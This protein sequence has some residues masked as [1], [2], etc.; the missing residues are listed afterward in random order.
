M[1]RSK[2]GTTVATVVCCSI[3]S[4]T[5]V[6]YG[7]GARRHGRSRFVRSYQRSKRGAR[8]IVVRRPQCS[9]TETWPRRLRLPT[10]SPPS[11]AARLRRS[12]ACRASATWST[13]RRPPSAPRSWP[14]PARRRRST[15]TSSSSRRR[16]S[17]PPRHRAHAADAGQAP[18]G[19]RQGDRRGEGRRPRAARRLRRRSQ[20][21]DLPS[22]DRRQGRRPLQGLPG[23]EEARLPARLRAAARPGARRLAARR[24]ARAQGDLPPDAA[25]R[26]R[27]PPPGPSSAACRRRSTSWRS[28]RTASPSASTTSRSSSPRR[29]SAT[30]SS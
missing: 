4:E 5:S 30:S 29:A 18:A 11:R 28:T 3:S 6:L 20:P 12:T 25:E 7:V 2:Y 23:A 24:G 16:G 8:R 27:R 1:K 26:A 14:R 15:T 9:T 21:V 17:T 10:S 19:G 13:R 22:A